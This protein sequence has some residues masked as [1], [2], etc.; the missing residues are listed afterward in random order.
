MTA[1]IKTRLIP[2][3]YDC[4]IPAENAEYMAL[5]DRLKSQGLK[6]FESWGGGKGHYMPFAKFK[7]SGLSVELEANQVFDNQWN[8]TPI[9]GFSEKG[10]RVFDWAQ[11][12]PIDFR[13][14]IKR[15]HYLEQVPEMSELRRNTAACGY[16]GKQEP[17]QKGYVFCPHCAGS[18]YLEVKDLFLTRMQAVS[19]AKDRAPLTEAETAYLLPIYKEAQLHGQ[20]ERGIAKMKKARETVEST[21]SKAIDK[22]ETEHAGFIWLLDKGFTI[23]NVI[24]YSHTNR[25][26]FGWRNPVASE[27]VDEL[28]QVISE[29]PFNYEIKCADGRTLA[30]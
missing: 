21:Y 17:M 12:H 3:H 15:G 13:K 7:E 25:F 24:Y 8:T 22:A 10:Y 20:G 27:L 30:N 4:E 14:S 5:V 11:D 9:L 26:S 6:C 23:E 2:Y 29:F 18:P 19:K 16:C 1:N 28:L